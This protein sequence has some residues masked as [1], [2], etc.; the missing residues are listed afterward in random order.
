MK[1]LKTLT[2]LFAASFASMISTANGVVVATYDFAVSAANQSPTALA[3]AGNTSAPWSSNFMGNVIAD[4]FRDP[5]NSLIEATVA[6]ALLTNRYVTFTVTPTQA[7]D[8]TAFSVLLGGYNAASTTDYT[9]GLAVFSSLTG[10]T[11]SAQLGSDSL[12]I[13]RSSSILDASSPLSIDLT[14]FSALQDTSDAVE[15]RIYV[16]DDRATDHSAFYVRVSDISVEAAAVPEPS[17][18]AFLLGIAALGLVAWRR[19]DRI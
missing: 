12:F 7:L 10:F 17:T 15:F 19:H 5:S 16:L 13:P 2:I 6:D 18:V 8:F 11:E 1:N 14:A 9:V 3:T 4:A